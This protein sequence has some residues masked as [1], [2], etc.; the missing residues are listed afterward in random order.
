[1]GY[2]EHPVRWM[3]KTLRMI[4]LPFTF[5]LEPRENTKTLAG[6]CQEVTI[7]FV[8]YEAIQDK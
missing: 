2:Q 7:S 6:K 1:V 8:C 5:P 4:Y 3:Q